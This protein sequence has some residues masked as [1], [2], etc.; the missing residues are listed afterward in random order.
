MTGKELLHKYNN[1]ENNLNTFITLE[2]II[3]IELKK[4]RKLK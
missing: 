4:A 3:D 2:E 1:Q